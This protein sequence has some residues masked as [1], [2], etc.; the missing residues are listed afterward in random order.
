MRCLVINLPNA[1]NRR[2]HI[3]AEFDRVGLPYE[4]R[5]ATSQHDLTEHQQQFVDQRERWR[6]GLRPIDR[7]ALAC[8]LSHMAV[9]Q[10]LVDSDADLVSVFED[11]AMLHP[12]LPMFLDALETG[13]D[14]DLAMLQRNTPKLPY[15]PVHQVTRE[16]TLGRIRY[17]DFG[18]YGYV[19]TR[20]TAAYQLTNFPDPTYEVDWILP[21]FWVNG[22]NRVYWA[23]PPLV[24]HN[25]VLPSQ[26]HMAREIMRTEH[27][28][29]LRR[30]FWMLGGRFWAMARQSVVRCRR[31]REVRRLD[32]ESGIAT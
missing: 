32:R 26:I 22:L 12:D 10:N 11:D 29:V 17:S 19:I 28:Q 14:F 31:W 20:Q 4:L 5:Q 9:W 25:D 13:P 7:P 2:E 18:A 15:T 21:R 3:A 8:L 23:N 24:F 30:R 27:R 16:H 6:R 1:W